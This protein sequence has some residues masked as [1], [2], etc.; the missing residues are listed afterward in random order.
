MEKQPERQTEKTNPLWKFLGELDSKNDINEIMINGAQ[1]IFVEQKGKFI[2]LKAEFSKQNLYDFIHDVAKFNK[3]ECNEESPI[4][5]GVLPNGNRIN[6]VCEP[7]A[8]GNPAI[9]IRKYIARNISLIS[10]PQLFGLGEEWALFLQAVVKAKLNCIVSGGTSVGKTT[11]LNLLLSE[12]TLSERIVVIEDTRELS[13]SIPNVVRLET[14][15]K[16]NKN[17]LVSTR[18]LVKNSLRMRP[19]RIIVGEVRGAEAFDLLQ[20]M[21]TGHDGSLSSIH[22]NSAR[23]SLFRLETLCLL[24]GYDL[25]IHAIRKQMSSAIDFIIH[26]KRTSKGERYVSVIRELTGMEGDT[27]ISQ[28]IALSDGGTLKWSGNTPEKYHKLVEIGG[29]P[30]NFFEKF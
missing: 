10:N 22:A 24:S 19:D 14:I 13:I 8:Y 11:F 29:L 4:L 9:S 17:Y 30:N 2:Q 7:V 21:N 16:S 3:K 20:A 27:I 1:N 25:P 18:D 5:D 6:I 26:L 12:I 23:E 15:Q 28:D